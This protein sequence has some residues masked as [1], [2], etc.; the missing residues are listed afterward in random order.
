MEC[1]WVDLVTEVRKDLFVEVNSALSGTH[2][3]PTCGERQH[4]SASTRVIS[5]L[6]DGDDRVVDRSRVCRLAAAAVT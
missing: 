2:M 6:D 1:G 5:M 4:L 3:E